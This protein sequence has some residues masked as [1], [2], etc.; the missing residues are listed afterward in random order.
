MLR[1]LAIASPWSHDLFLKANSLLADELP[2]FLSRTIY[3]PPA[4]TDAERQRQTDA[5]KD[6]RVAQPAL[7]SVELFAT[8]WLE[9]YAVRPAFVAGHSY[10]EYVALHIAGCLSRSDLLRLSAYRGRV[11]AE[12]AESRP[13]AM[14]A[15]QADASATEAAL[16]ELNI[17][18]DV[19]NR[20]GPEQTVIAGPV[21]T[22]EIAI[23]QLTRRGLRARKIPVSAAFH[24]TQLSPAADA[25]RA[26]L[27]GIAFQRPRIPV[28]SNTTGGRHAEE[29]DGIRELLCRHLSEPVLFEREV[30]QLFD[31]GARVFLEVGPGRVLT[32]LVAHIL[33]DDAVTA[34]SLDV[35]GR[36]GWTQMGHLLARL[37]VLGLPVRLDAWFEGR[38]LRSGSVADFL[39]RARAEKAPN[40]TDWIISP[41]TARPVTPLPGRKTSAIPAADQGS[42]SVNGETK[43]SSPVKPASVVSNG[44]GPP[45]G[46]RNPRAEKVLPAMTT[47]NGHPPGNGEVHGTAPSGNHLF[48]QFQT[49]TR[50]LLEA[51]QAQNRVLER[52]LE[53]QERILLHCTQ[54]ALPPTIQALAESPSPLTNGLR[55]RPAPAVARP[56]IPIPRKEVAPSTRP[57]VVVQPPAHPEQFKMVAAR[58]ENQPTAS[59]FGASDGPPPTE[60]FRQD[61]LEVVS[62]RTGYP[63]DALD[64]ALALEA[65]LGIDSIKT[66]EIFSHLKAYHAYFRAEDQ[67]EEELLAEFTKLKTLRDI[68]DAYDRRRQ[69]YFA[70]AHGNGTVGPTIR[71][72]FDAE[73]TNGKVNRYTVTPA[74]APLER[75]GV[76]KNDSP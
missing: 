34:L 11:C 37:T 22:I 28:Y 31:D 5:L 51:Q 61:L 32:D 63:I 46:I 54:A 27:N 30:R 67:E 19:A 48:D 43:K 65:E 59:D 2:Q 76:K 12:A 55:V 60:K 47:T 56:P 72:N 25:M 75:N 20:N 17:A 53:T 14:A 18:A 64:E 9:R 66:V 8:D 42:I 15:V 44:H 10:G 29:P 41:N 7:G 35:P 74:A 68:L 49:T 57:S 26:Y 23:G 1:D 33:P 13:G 16:K 73:K 71:D 62:T 69:V 58:T 4:F 24:T 45:S 39:A 50:L 40:P 38:G 70:A 6:T 36:D 3:P 52:F 21:E